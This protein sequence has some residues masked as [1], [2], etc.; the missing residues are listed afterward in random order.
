VTAILIKQILVLEID[1]GRD[2]KSASD[3]QSERSSAVSDHTRRTVAQRCLIATRNKHRDLYKYAMATRAQRI[4]GA[5]HAATI[6]ACAF[7]QS[8]ARPP[9][10]DRKQ[11][12]IM[13]NTFLLSAGTNIIE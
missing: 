11:R 4:P 2:L 3:G 13:V 6:S 8:A 12:S 9:A 10:V 1:R 5:A 7:C